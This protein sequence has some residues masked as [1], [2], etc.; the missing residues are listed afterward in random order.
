MQREITFA[1]ARHRSRKAVP[2]F[3]PDKAVWKMWME[4][5]TGLLYAHRFW[6][7]LL[8]DQCN[9][10]FTHAIKT[11]ATDGEAILINPEYFKGLSYLQ[12]IFATAHEIAHIML[13]HCELGWYWQRAGYI[14]VEQSA[15]QLFPGVPLGCLPYI[16]ELANIAQDFV[17]NALLTE[18]NVGHRHPDWLFNPKYVGATSSVFVYKDLFQMNP[19]PPPPPGGG[20]QGDPGDGDGDEDGQGGGDGDPGDGQ[21][22]GQG[23]GKGTAPVNLPD[24][25]QGNSQFDQHMAPGAQ[26]KKSPRQATEERQGKKAR[27]EQAIRKAATAARAAGQMPAGLNRFIEEILEPPVDWKDMLPTTLARTLGSG[28]YDYRRGLRQYM[29]R[30][31]GKRMFVPSPSG[32]GCGVIVIGGDSSGSM[33]DPEVAM[34]CACMAGIITDA[35]PKL[36]HL[37]WCDTMVHRVDEVID[38]ADVH[39]VRRR[40]AAG[41]GGTRFKPV[42]DWV[43]ENEIR[44]DCLIYITDMEGPMDFPEPPYPVIWCSIARKLP[45]PWGEVIEI[46]R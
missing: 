40:G 23:G 13:E 44:P 31:I 38:L 2:T 6:G 9:V 19:P 32:H 8:A 14:T 42:F 12:R 15:T 11:L 21:Q 7:V 5:R 27:W 17:I 46:P 26:A 30:P 16:H 29:N 43:E 25:T 34:I 10:L 41:G 45:A 18:N 33:S 22:D 3:E 28:G 1:D 37:A 20:G 36:I 4:T 35:R 24:G 39:E